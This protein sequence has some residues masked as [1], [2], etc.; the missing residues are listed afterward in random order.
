M[1]VPNFS[2]IYIHMLNNFSDT[3]RCLLVGKTKEYF[4]KSHEFEIR[5]SRKA[6]IPLYKRLAAMMEKGEVFIKIHELSSCRMNFVTFH[7]IILSI[8][9]V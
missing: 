8:F 7:V 6:Y 9:V 5:Q 1:G 2:Y 4:E 3:A